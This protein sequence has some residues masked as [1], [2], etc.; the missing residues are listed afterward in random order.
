[1]SRA[2][3]VL[4]AFLLFLAI[5]LL[6]HLIK[7]PG[8]VPYLM[9]ITGN[10][11][12]L[13]LKA[14]FS[15]AE[16]Y[17]RLE[18]FGDLGRRMYLRTMLTVDIVFPLS[19]FAFLLLLAAFAAERLK[20]VGP[21]RR[22]LMA[23]PIAYLFLDFFENMTVV[24]LLLNFPNQIEFL[25]SSIGYLTVGKRVCMYAA[26]LIPISLLGIGGLLTSMARREVLR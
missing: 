11:P 12:I 4:T 22:G 23:L 1:M 17:Q 10:Q 21:A 26:L 5:L 2:K 3:Q 20:L 25:A 24:I 7:L 15:S 18:A 8:T 6:T 16:T 19:A 14:S 13:D 9:E